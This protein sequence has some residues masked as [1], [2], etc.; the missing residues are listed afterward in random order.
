[1][2]RPLFRKCCAEFLGTFAIVL[3]GCG[4]VTINALSDGAIAHYGIATAFGLIVM[5]M[6]YALGHVSGAHFNPAVSIA[7]FITRHFPKGELLPYILFQC[8]GA[9]TASAIHWATL[10]HIWQERFPQLPLVLGVTQPMDGQWWTAVIWE[11]LLT[12]FLM[13]VIMAVATDHRAVG[14]AAGL[15][16]GGTVWFEAMFAGPL[17][18]A[19]MNPARSLGPAL[20]SG[21][22]NDF[23]AYVVGPVL[24]AMAGGLVY[25][26]V[27]HTETESEKSD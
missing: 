24:G 10:S 11:F 8:A 4:A 5:T 14:Q 18:G 23:G 22:W 1:M 7:F 3:G 20:L 26:F 19:S 25:Q 17:T 9:I 13:L 21:N 15:A 2:N 16:I 6:I 12:F 27:A